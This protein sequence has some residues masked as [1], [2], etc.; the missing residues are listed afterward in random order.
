MRYFVPG[1][2]F[3]PGEKPEEEPGE[4]KVDE[5]GKKYR[6]VAPGC[7]EYAPT[8]TIDGV[9][10]ETTPE[11][12][13]A[14]HAGNRAAMERQRAEQRQ[15]QAQE[16]TGRFCPFNV[17][18]SFPPECKTSCALY[19]ATGCAQKRQKAPQD[20]KGKPCPFLRVCSEQCA[21][22]DNGCCL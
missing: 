5:H 15:R 9:E 22:Y 16:N 11:A 18:A 1:P 21:I 13:E 19:R 20:T 12:L 6:Q 10:V 8:I 3:F 17:N 2:G 7:I 14:F 4:W